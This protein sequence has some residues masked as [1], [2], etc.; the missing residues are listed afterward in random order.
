MASEKVY[1]GKAGAQEL[2]T[3]VEGHID[4]RIPKVPGAEGNVG[5]FTVDGSLE[6][7]GVSAAELESA[8]QDDHTHANKEVLDATTASYTTEEQ[9]KLGNV[10]AGAEVNEIVTVKVDGTALTPDED[11][12]VDIDLSGKVDKVQGKQ[13]STEDYTTAEK[14]KLGNIEA[15]AEVNLIDTVEVD[16]SALVITGKTVNIPG[17][18]ASVKGVVLLT[19]DPES[20]AAN[21]AATPT[22]IRAALANFGG[23][24]VVELDPETGKPDVDEPSTKYIYLT[25]EEDS[26]KEDPYTEWIYVVPEQ[27]EPHWDI[28]GT[29]TVDLS[30][31][32]QKVPGG[33]QGDLAGLAADGGIVDSGISGSDVSDAVGKRHSHSNKATLDLVE[34]P[35]TTAEKTKLAG[36]GNYVESASVSGRTLTLTPKSGEAVEFT[37]T[38]DVNTIESISVNDVAVSPVNKN[39]NI[40]IPK[41]V[42]G[43]TAGN[44]PKLDANGDLVDSGVAASALTSKAAADGGTDLSLVTTGEKY[45][46]NSIGA[47]V[48]YNSSTG[49]LHLDFSPQ[50]NNG[51]N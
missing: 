28:I 2:Y 39:V 10:E 12:A 19:D 46:W 22:A 13:L 5:K 21:T 1:V 27:G 17:A 18:T 49:E 44:I 38:G 23:F 16:G 35:Y 29:A 43:G 7:T 3:R 51:G 37:E 48:S 30:G 8:V 11:R 42:P 26:G 9:G 40:V 15:N 47:A 6:D 32:V 34:E 20:E 14:D 41:A 36:I 25:K 50:V 33:T 31:Y 4:A 45:A 24:M